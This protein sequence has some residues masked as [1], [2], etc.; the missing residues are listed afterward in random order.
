MAS[1]CIILRK[2]PYGSVDAAEAIR[3]ALGGATTEDVRTSLIL[4]DGGVNAARRAQDSSGTS[5]MSLA[6]GIRDSIDMG[7]EVYADKSSLKDEFIEQASL[8]D[9]VRVVNGSEIAGIIA[10]SDVTMIF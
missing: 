9:G 6:E 5:Y 1:V 4:V 3:H 10:A 2:P 7:A 8:V